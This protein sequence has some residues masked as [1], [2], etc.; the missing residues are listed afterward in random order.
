MSEHKVVTDKVIPL[1][2]TMKVSQTLAII[3]DMEVDIILTK[4][5]IAALTN[6]VRAT[7]NK[8]QKIRMML[9]AK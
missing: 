3:T 5:E 6:Q 8:I 2:D 9:E 7:S 4:R 1:P